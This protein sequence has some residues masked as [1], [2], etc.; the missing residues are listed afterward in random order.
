[1]PALPYLHPILHVP[2]LVDIQESLE[3]IQPYLQNTPVLRSGGLDEL[4]QA[5]LWFKCE[6]FQRVGA[7]KMR[8]ALRAAMSIPEVDR[9]CGLATHSSGNHAQAV[10]LTARLMGVPA[11]VVMPTNAPAPKR[12]ATE[13]YGAEIIPCEPTLEAREQ[14]LKDVVERTHAHFIPPFNDYNIIAGQGTS[15]LELLETV[16]DLD[17]IIAPV[18]GG[19]LISG[20]LLAAK[21]T[22]PNIHV[23]AAEPMLVDD[24]FRSL[25]S[26]SLQKN[27]RTDTMADG[28]R[29]LLGPKNFEVLHQG[30]DGVLRVEEH[31]ILQALIFIWERLKV[32]IEPSAA[33]AFAAALKYPDLVKGKRAG[34][35]LSGGN[36]DLRQLITLLAK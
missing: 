23:Y 36:A 9:H 5:Q 10:A 34:I 18:G 22:N 12:D 3:A 7:F 28:L 19:G 16:P 13:G 26:G 14:G 29:T 24:A 2:T 31:E 27:D 4:A 33:V 1:M 21:G 35:I 15:A 11:Y 32:V 20:T 8:G 30:L 6:S 25:Q 17:L